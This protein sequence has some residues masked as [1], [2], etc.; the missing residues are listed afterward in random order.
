MTLINKLKMNG[1]EGNTFQ[2][3]KKLE[4]QS[5]SEELIEMSIDD[6]TIYEGIK[7]VIIGNKHLR[8]E[9]IGMISNLFIAV[10]NTEG[11]VGYI[12][13]NF[14]VTHIYEIDFRNAN[15]KDIADIIED[16]GYWQF[17]KSCNVI[18][19]LDFKFKIKQAGIING[20][21]IKIIEKQY[22]MTIYKFDTWCLHQYSNNIDRYIDTDQYNTQIVY[23]EDKGKVSKI[24]YGLINKR[25]AYEGT[26]NKYIIWKEFD[27]NQ[28]NI[29]RYERLCFNEK[30]LDN[31][32]TKFDLDKKMTNG[33]ITVEDKYFKV[34]I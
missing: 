14:K 19:S 2:I 11:I 34:Y 3:F 12:D 16:R 26:N 29:L 9:F 13:K 28:W 5:G 33:L 23:L 4:V 1:I 31:C 32:Y 17:E 25:V 7:V 21:P 18:T 22:T 10:N 15:F 6:I 27:N 30:G 24:G 8:Y 20:K